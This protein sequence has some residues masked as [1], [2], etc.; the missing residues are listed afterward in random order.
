MK[1]YNDGAAWSVSFDGALQEVLLFVEGDSIER[2]GLTSG[3]VYAMMHT[4]QDT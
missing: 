4:R 2:A 1:W 3:K